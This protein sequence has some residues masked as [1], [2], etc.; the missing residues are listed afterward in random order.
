MA[1]RGAHYNIRQ[2]IDRD[3]E[4]VVYSIIRDDA[5]GMWTRTS[6][7]WFVKDQVYPEDY[8]VHM[9]ELDTVGETTIKRGWMG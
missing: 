9:A 6:T 1:A 5:E 4:G 8:S 3:A 7:E 2:A